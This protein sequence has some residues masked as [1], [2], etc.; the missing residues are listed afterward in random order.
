MRLINTTTKTPKEF[1]TSKAPPYAIL[2]HT[3]ADG[4]ITYQ[5]L[6]HGRKKGKEAG[7]AKLHNGCRVAAA[8]GYDYFW[9][10]TCCIDKTNNVE[11]SEAINSMFQWYKQAGICFA[12]LADVPAKTSTLIADSPF[13]RSK[14]FTR[15]W[16]LQELLAPPQVIFLASDWTEIATKTKLVLPI[17]DVTGIPSDFLLGKDL[18]KASVAMRMSWAS[19]RETTKAEDIAYYLLG[20]FDIQMP[21]LAIPTSDYEDTVTTPISRY[22]KQITMSRIPIAELNPELLDLDSKQIRAVVTLIWPW[23]S[24]ARQFALLL[25]EPEFRLRR[26]N[27]QVRARFTGSSARALATSGVGI[28]DEVVL[29]LRGASFVR[30]GTISTPGK[31]IDYEL[32][33]AQTVTA[34]ITRDGNELADL[35]L[36]DVTPTP[37]TRSP[38]RRAP[39]KPVLA[40]IEE[41][42]KWSSPAFLKRT[43][44]SDGPVFEAGYDPFE[45][46]VEDTHARKRRRKSYRDWN[47]WTYSARTPSPEKTGVDT[48]DYDMLEGSPTRAP[49]LPVTPLSP[50]KPQ[51]ISVAGLPL[52]QS[53]DNP[54]RE[55]NYDADGSVVDKGEEDTVHEAFNLVQQQAEDR[56]VP[57]ED[58]RY[59]HGGDTEPNTEDEEELAVALYGSQTQVSDAEDGSEG[60]DPSSDM[61]EVASD[62]DVSEEENEVPLQP[63]SHVVD[64]LSDEDHKSDEEDPAL[65]IEEENVHVETPSNVEEAATEQVQ[66]ARERS[67]T[68]EDLM[69][70]D[71]DNND[72][73]VVMAPPP[74]LPLLQTDLQATPT[75]RILTPLG[76]EPQSPNLRPLDSSTLPMPSPFPGERDGDISSYFEHAST[77]QRNE[78]PPVENPEEAEEEVDYTIESSFFSSIN[79]ASAFHESAF[80]D[81]RFTF[82]MDGAAF[83]RTK[84]S[85]KPHDAEAPVGDQAEIDV[86]QDN[87]GAIQAHRRFIE[88]LDSS[89]LGDDFS[90]E[91]SAEEVSNLPTTYPIL[92]PD[93]AT[94]QEA[95]VAEVIDLSSGSAEEDIDHQSPLDHD[96][97]LT[98]DVDD[99]AD[100]TERDKLFLDEQKEHDGQRQLVPQ[101]APTNRFVDDMTI[102]ME[103]NETPVEEP[104]EAVSQKDHSKSRDSTPVEEEITR[105]ETREERPSRVREGLKVEGKEGP[106]IT[107]TIITATGTEIIDLGSSSEEESDMEESATESYNTSTQANDSGA[108]DVTVEQG[109]VSLANTNE[110]DHDESKSDKEEPPQS[111]NNEP[112]SIMGDDSHDP[113]HAGLLFDDEQPEFTLTDDTDVKMESIE[114]YAPLNWQQ[115][116]SVPSQENDEAHVDTDADLLISI[117]EEGYKVGE[118]QVKAVPSTAPARNTRSKTKNSTSMSPNKDEQITPRRTRPSRKDKVSAIAITRTTLSPS[119]ISPAKD[120]TPVSPYSLRS[121]SKLLSPMKSTIFGSQVGSPR[122]RSSKQ[123][124]IDVQSGYDQPALGDSFQ[125]VDL[126]LPDLSFDQVQ[127]VDA[128]QG[129]FSNVD[130]VKDSEEGSLHSESSLSTVQN[131]DDW[132]MDLHTYTN[133]SDP[134]EPGTQIREGS[135]PRRPRPTDREI[136]P[137]T[138][139]RRSARAG[140]ETGS[141]VVLPVTKTPPQPARSTPRKNRA[142]VT[143]IQVASSSPR[144]SHRLK[145]DVYDRLEDEDETQ[146]SPPPTQPEEKSSMHGKMGIIDG[147]PPAKQTQFASVNQHSVMNSNMPMTPEATQQTHASQPS[148]PT[149]PQEQSIPLTPQLT[150]STSADLRSFKTLTE[151]GSQPIAKT[152]PITRPTSHGNVTAKVTA[153]TSRSISPAIKSEDIDASTT[154]VPH[155]DHE[156]PSVGLSTPISYYTP[157]K[158]LRFFLN[159]SSQF[160]STSYPDV[161]AL[162][163]SPTT[164]PKQATKG[165]KHWTT[166]L[167]ITDLSFHPST[168]TVQV[169]RAFKEALPVAHKGDIVL[170]RAFSVKSLNR[171]PMLISAEESAWCVWKYDGMLWGKKRGAF[172]DVR[173]REEVNGPS[174]ERGQ[175]EWREVEKLRAWYVESVAMEIGAEGEEGGV[176]TRSQELE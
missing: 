137:A 63:T 109:L 116:Q 114:E 102:D 26:R 160:H 156:P 100:N 49:R 71:D 48:E 127:E 135:T 51:R 169:F 67:G 31:S 133:F 161:L 138:P 75:P 57:A 47:K 74:T 118:L 3:W 124:S 25:A 19:N 111:A 36:A 148:F 68:N 140:G 40:A 101:Q 60:Y 145:K 42:K 55:G 54:S 175:G 143:P 130:Y 53:D 141:Q 52:E 97:D 121:Q 163:T 93:S 91:P 103:A 87:Q 139:S 123:K 88:A 72:S 128:S 98:H 171:Q 24:S 46:D 153:S 78:S 35:D 30:E 107:K 45:A 11:L 14:W 131:S 126:A 8:A 94:A 69:V 5:D 167:H 34:Q 64:L 85:P 106:S 2:S 117:P 20:I 17:M 168:T 13:S 21:L 77:S 61:V 29:S 99:I 73:P 165:P 144:R 79:S 125:S 159:R 7:Y 50:E 152:S 158:D 9:I 142:S 10:D 164:A 108:E 1:E 80:T 115:N 105:P 122:K 162:V 174:V 4:E 96:H 56:I 70:L 132:N 6:V 41:P 119:V 18:E 104:V 15:G 84:E 170:L 120:T 155:P 157:L 176:K 43:R 38:V 81:V 33:Y 83:S 90:F 66:R 149:V 65:S 129:K 27:G 12:Y 147:S 58:N 166:T 154:L 110:P 134:V 112:Q 39:Y 59:N 62:E 89:D 37:A 28:G 113:M 44:V 151:E 92:P 23:S 95:K 22:S 146:S 76:I 32:E 136:S 86:A 82:G 16:T 172:G 150:Q 173:S